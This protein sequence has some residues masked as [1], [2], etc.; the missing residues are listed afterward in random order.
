LDRL[1]HHFRLRR[2]G[3]DKANGR[4]AEDLA[5]RYLEDLGYIVIARNYMARGGQGE[6]DLVARDGEALV[7][8]EVK[9]RSSEDFGSP[10][11][12]VNREK[13]QKVIRA[14]FE[15][16]R[17]A[18]FPEECMRFDIVS[19]VHGWPPK[20]DYYKDAFGTK[21]AASYNRFFRP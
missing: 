15:Y 3:R 8:V 17:R 18:G 5:H 21:E 16:A 12:A 4:L 11:E 20:L 1:R 7:V 10:D 9:S 13:R 14:A 19:V 2:W 6:L